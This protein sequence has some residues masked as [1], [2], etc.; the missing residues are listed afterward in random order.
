MLNLKVKI[1]KDD[2]SKDT[3]VVL[4]GDNVDFIKNLFVKYT[5][6]EAYCTLLSLIKSCFDGG[7]WD[8]Y[9]PWLND[10]SWKN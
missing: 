2:A 8:N 1:L 3:T 5:A 7:F 6:L 4:Y 10:T 9:R